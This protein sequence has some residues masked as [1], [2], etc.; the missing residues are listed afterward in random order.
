MN[1]GVIA[2]RL[3]QSAEIVTFSGGH[4]GPS[5]AR[6]LNIGYAHSWVDVNS[7]GKNG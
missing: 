4:V 1:P 6:S 7:W 2:E 5:H 3:I